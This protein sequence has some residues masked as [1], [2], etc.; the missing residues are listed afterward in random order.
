MSV[1]LNTG[2]R[3]PA[4]C[5]SLG[6]VMM[7]ALSN[8]DLDNYFSRVPLRPMTE[9]TVVSEVR[10]REILNET[11]EQGYAIVEEE[12]EIGLRSIAVPMR[13]ASGTVAAALKM[14]AQSSRV[15]REQMEN[16]FLPMLLNGASE[17]S[18]L[19]P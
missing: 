19:L 1:A 12:L 11:A 2:S 10:L 9:H 8:A 17:L 18:M 16:E 13:G 5:T 15:S 6:R 14:G 7:A 4:Y 3:I